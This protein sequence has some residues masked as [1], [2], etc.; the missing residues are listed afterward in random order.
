MIR[1]VV[2][3]VLTLTGVVLSGDDVCGGEVLCGVRC[4]SVDEDAAPAELGG[5]SGGGSDGAFGLWKTGWETP[6]PPMFSPGTSAV[7]ELIPCLEPWLLSLSLS[8]L[9]S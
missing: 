2:G 6:S 7:A 5:N 4:L 9:S 3:V 1:P 8:L